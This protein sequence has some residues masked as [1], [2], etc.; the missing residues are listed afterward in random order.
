MKILDI[1]QVLNS[2]TPVWPG[3][4]PFSFRLIWTKEETG[5][6]NVGTITMSAHTGTHID[7]P[8]HFTD[9]G[10]RV[11]K[12]PLHSYIGNALVIDVSNYEAI[13]SQALAGI[14]L[15]TVELVLIALPLKI[16]GAD[17]VLFVRC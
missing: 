17:G 13:S 16:E 5:S 7:A 15:T 10:S 6:V 8:Y 9:D 3:S 11:S 14:D 2:L 4:T 1:S 12:L